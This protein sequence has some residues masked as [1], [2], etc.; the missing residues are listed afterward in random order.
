MSQ[1]LAEVTPDISTAE[2]LLKC[3]DERLYQAKKNGRNN[4]VA[5]SF[6]C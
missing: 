3:A 6:P 2:E 1:G 4:I 5:K